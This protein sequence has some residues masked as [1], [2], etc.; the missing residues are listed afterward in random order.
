M[1]R[2]AGLI[3]FVSLA[4]AGG[5]CETIAANIAVGSIPGSFDV[6]LSGS[7][8][9][10]VPIKIAPGAAGTQPQ[11][12]L[13]YD[14]QTIGGPLGAG[15]SLGGFS[16]ITRGPKDKFVDGAP[17]AIE[18]ED[19]GSPNLTEQDALYLDGQRL[20]PV[21]GPT[22]S[23][24]DRQ[25]EYRKVND[26]FT[27]VV[28]FGPDLGHSYF[29]ARTKGGV[30]LIFGNPAILAAPP[31]NPSELDATIRVDNGAGPVLIF[32]ESA[33]ID[34]AGN[35]ITFHY[36]SN[37]FGDYNIT[38]VDYTGH[39]R[40]NDKGVISKDRDPFASVTFIYETAARP[41]ELYVGG[42]LLRKD[43]RLTEIYSCVSSVTLVAPF[44][45]KVAISAADHNVHQTAHYKLDYIDTQT[46][47]RFVVSAVH[48]FGEDDANEISPTK[49]TYSVANPG[50]DQAQIPLPDGL[51]IADTQQIARGNRFAHFVPDPAGG[52]DLLF[53]AE[54]GGKKVA[55][56]FKN[57]GPASW[58]TGGQP[59]SAASKN[60]DS[61][62]PYD[63]EPPVPFVGE[64]G[65]DLGVILGDIDGT[66]RTAILQNNVLAGQTSKSAY[67][68]GSN[69]FE[70]HPEYELP[71]IVSKDGKVVA[72]YRFG[73]WTGG[74]GPDLLFESEGKKGLLRNAGPGSGN[75]WKPLPDDF[76]PP[77]PLDARAHLVDLDCSGG[78][79]ALIGVVRAADGTSEWK[80]YRLGA[81][82]WEEDTDTKWQP[83]FPASTNPEAVREI[84]FDGPSSCAGLIV[85]E[86]G[87]VHQAMMPSPTGWRLLDKAPT[88]KTPIFDL[89]D[90]AGHPSRAVVANLKGDGYDGIVANTL[91]PDGSAIAFA[92]TQD[93]NGWHDASANF[94][95][96]TALS[97]DD[98]NN[99]VYA[100]VG[101]IVG[102][103]GDDIAILNDQRVTASNDTGRNRQFG[104]F[105]VNDGTGFAV[106]TSFAP[107]IPFATVDKTDLGVRFIDLHGSGL[108][109]V[110]FSRLVSKNGKTYLVSGAYRNTGHGWIPAPGLCID[111]NKN[112]D[113]ADGNPPM[114]S[115]LCPP[116]PFAGSDVT[117][118]PVQLVDLDGDGFVDMIYSYKDK[119]GNV[120]TRLY[121]N[122]SDGQ[123]GRAWVDA[124][125]DPG[126]FGKFLPSPVI[127]QVV[128]PLASSGIGDMGVRFV[129]FDTHRVGV[130]KSFREGDKICV[131]GAC[132]PK[133]GPWHRGAF[134]FDGDKWID[135]GPSYIPQTPFVTQYDSTTGPAIDHFVQ[136][137]D[138]NG[139]GLPSIVANYQDPATGSRINN[140]WI[141]SGTGWV[142]SGIQVPYALDAVYWES[143]T[144]VQIVDVNG[145]GLA[146]IVMTKGD[147]PAN[148][149]TWL[150]TG[151]GWIESPNWQVP[152]DA[153]SNKDGEPGY[154]LVDTKGDGYL[155]VLWMRPDKNG[156]PDRGL[157][158]NNGHDWSM[159]A[160]DVVPKT[161]VFANTDGVDQGV[162]LISVTGKG[163]TDIV[164]SFAGRQQQV[165]LNR[166]RRADVLASVTD[167]YGITTRVSYETLLEYDC[168]DSK[169]GD[170]CQNSASGVQRN[171][172]GWRA[173]ERESPD[174]FPKVA[175][176]PTTYVVRQAIVDE[177]DGQPPVAIDYR[178][179][180]YQVDANAARSLGFG[181]RESLNEFSGI[182]TRSEMV[183]DARA[184]P[185]VAIETSCVA[186]TTVLNAM[187]RKALTSNDLMDRFPTNLC[188]Q[189]DQIALAWGYK[190]S[191]NDTC[192]TIAE[193]DTQG[194]VNDVQL[195]TTALCSK[196]GSGTP[197]AIPTIR[198]SAISKSVS[199]SFELDGHIISKV[200]D[201]FVYDAAGDILSRHGNVISTVSALGDGSSIETANEYSDDSSRWFLGRLTKTRVTKIG[202]L[203]GGGADRKTEKRC[204]RFEYAEETGL[205]S[206]QE[207]NCESSKAVT[208]RMVRD[209]FGNVAAKSA[210]AFG[211]PVQTSRSEY[212]VFGRFVVSTID[213]LGHRSSAERNPA[214]GQPVSTTDVNGLTTTFTFDGFGRLRRQTS[215]TGIST[216]TDLL[217]AIALPKIDDIRDFGWGLSAPVKYAVRSQVGSL[218]PTW[219]LFDAK[220]R[221]IRNVADGYTA[222][223]SNTRYIFKETEY[224]SLGRVSRTSVP[225]EAADGDVRWAVNEYD[226]LGRICASTAI[227][228]LR[229]E[230]L[231]TGRADGGGTVTVVVDPK[232]QLS[233]PPR[234]GSSDPLLSC[235]HAFPIE[236]Y[237]RNGLNQLASSTVNMRKQMVESADA[238]GKVTF[239]FD[240]GGRMQKT[241]GPTGATTINTYDELGNKIAGTDPDL[242]LWRYEYDP[243]GRVVR[244]FDAKRQVATME[245]DVAGRPTRRAAG[246][247][248]TIWEYDTAK[249]GIGKVA[250][251]VNSN[252]YREDF[253]YDVFGRTSGNAVQIDKEQYLTVNELD[254]YGRV[255]HVSYPNA[256]GVQNSYDGKGFLVSV[257]DATSSRKTYWTVK[258]IDVLG[259]V[260][261][262]TFGNGVTTKKHFDP[263][264][265]RIHN[266]AARGAHGQR[267]MD[268]TLHY[269]AIGN[270]K[271]RSE[272]VEHKDESFEYDALNRLVALVS[273]DKKEFKYDAA[274][275]FT[276]KAGIGNFHYAGHPGEIDGPYAK[277]FHAVLRTNHR[278]FAHHYKYDLNGNMVSAPEGHFDYT[279]DNHLKL[280][281]FEENKWSTF[282]H[283]PTGDRF[284][285]FSRLGVESQETLYVGLFEK[286]IYYSLPANSDFLR[287]PKF[288]GFSRLTR[289]RN[290]IANGSGVF[291]VVETEDTY[292]QT[293]LFQARSKPSIRS[294]AKQ[295]TTE[296]WYMHADQ[297]GSILRV[298]DQDGRIRAR[299]WYDPWG[300]RT[301][302]EDDRRGPG[303]AQ[304][305][306]G[307][308]KRGFTGQEHLDA[309]PLIH[310]NGRVYNA[311]LGVFT[312]V[313][314]V[315][316]M[317]AD[318]QSGNGY[319]YTRNNPLR[320]IDPSG[321]GWDPIGDIKNGLEG[322]GNA[323]AGGARAFWNGVSHF[324]G[325]VGKWWSENWRT[326]VVIVVVVV[327]TYF[328]LGAGSGVAI[329]L[330]DA[331]LAGAAAGA[332]GGAVGAALYGGSPD[333]ILQAAVKGAVIGA[334]SAAAFYGVGE[335]FGATA[336]SSSSSQVES[337]AAH[338]V[339]GGAKSAV[340]G[341]DFWKG[342][343]ATAATKA[344]NLYGPQYQNFAARDASA[345]VVGGTTSQ[346]TGGKFVNGAVT[347]AFS[348]AFND[349]LHENG[350][351]AFG[352]HQRI[353]VEN[354]NGK[355]LEGISF[356]TTSGSTWLSSAFYGNDSPTGG[357][358]G[359][360]VVYEDVDDPSTRI[361]ERFKTTSDENLAIEKYMQDRLGETGKYNIW[362]NSCIN[363]CNQQYNYI[364]SQIE[365]SRS[366]Y[367]SPV[368]GR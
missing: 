182:L 255:T 215:P 61:G 13:N 36:Q 195:P 362:T 126:K 200:T 135:A 146:D 218:R 123:G 37:G 234:V 325:E 5:S 34:T 269:D 229:T 60:V 322:L 134:A 131:F 71:F 261:E 277:P 22:G 45:C 63:F 194:H 219:A 292:A 305:V 121:F 42:H 115:G 67:L 250:S 287:P 18:F 92:F 275:R 196:P 82:K 151:G 309:F 280:I 99:P 33:A 332:A 241:V 147:T 233:G 190:I 132:F 286:T 324:A 355:I 186:D 159:R 26:D 87:G 43:R 164:A 346:L 339:V 344:A 130:L 140:I 217:G 256:F 225:H 279:S 113:T 306:A 354:E 336:Q 288:S 90:A 248:S 247:V 35:F 326:V 69:S 105:Y 136:I 253:Y 211:E 88:N 93:A 107:P 127:S 235:G 21:R 124:A 111:P 350:S 213:V 224:D 205:L 214:T 198:Q 98:P 137:L 293:G 30:T 334:I 361:I 203:I 291:A 112:F 168:S 246:D 3:L 268:L 40:I 129:K 139:S 254:A 41:I 176:V 191:E 257:S 282:D 297:L 368:L 52:L 274:G 156:K 317:I 212:D 342:F 54:I 206:A 295:S 27:E 183:Q 313:D 29:R 270:L 330:G 319:S 20:V 81:T 265:E 283:G 284:R 75:G 109:D 273:V 173:Y 138:F 189:G 133:V 238:F 74:V 94:I 285:Q 118:N 78:K 48:M 338:G 25:I 289:S 251:I 179:G 171:P 102:Q 267:V 51:V 357:G 28:Q 315:N 301:I 304:R 145:D 66:G 162:R 345:A 249:H 307:S 125:S 116:I 328:T 103:G 97:S 223:A 316:Q 44:N 278:R 158:L 240:A 245:Y 258:N 192:W 1:R 38:E 175:P 237:R 207:V 220:G 294:Y 356:G 4:A 181:W 185:G 364:K 55:Y 62:A 148:S 101:P 7:S 79:P 365:K 50:W 77:I 49:F 300:A 117:G 163:L 53:A 155:D 141:N 302:K 281:Y 128:F 106:Q 6:S 100:F 263:S 340:E 169:T 296:A 31:A 12:Q 80:V 367:H 73:N 110:V 161:L 228:G 201:T 329:T 84:R 184:R 177:R 227:N 166:G 311:S 299:F 8:S 32:A 188:Q 272:A 208:T 11:I 262:E 16:A 337:M 226:A 276:F 10:S 180:K 341:G 331:I 366:E 85:A 72:N 310:M 321:L 64:D 239:Q 360:G 204:S 303:E 349:F 347:G 298:T 174:A 165:D 170:D 221:Q 210:F 143:K 314:P 335:A 343:V 157:A 56:A 271:N 230:T 65:G 358:T 122:E 197:V 68:P 252:G 95:P 91:L 86:G 150:G 323:L 89:V 14:S 353:V 232:R 96:D 308:W 154:R 23:G 178:Y 266:I 327:V 160:D 187:V 19:G 363:F 243:F 199:T 290:Y 120:V 202:D 149:K 83:K 24:A 244:Q 152:T 359:T 114:K 9:Y 108:P 15:W 193:G 236:L 153:I 216:T 47:S 2:G 312:S 142:S 104:K 209:V 59:W 348:Y 144:L 167:G 259:R 242:G 57:N 231:F 318:T 172:L 352:F 39:G 76:A 46:A 17:G 222:D 58:T 264:D 260:T 119:N 320:Y 351:Q 333:D 70:A